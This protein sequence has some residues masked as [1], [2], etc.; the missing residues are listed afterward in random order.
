MELAR[1]SMGPCEDRRRVT[2]A[3]AKLM[4]HVKTEM[5][6][7]YYSTDWFR[8]RSGIAS[9]GRLRSSDRSH[10]IAMEDEAMRRAS[11]NFDQRRPPRSPVTA[12]VVPSKDVF[13]QRRLCLQRSRR[14]ILFHLS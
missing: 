1:R 2:G 12:K 5:I 7:L 10:V 6:V 4:P 3:E 9:E 13:T 8:Y 11:S 14:R